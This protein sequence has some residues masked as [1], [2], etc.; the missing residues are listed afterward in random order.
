MTLPTKY[1]LHGFPFD[2]YTFSPS[3]KPELD[4]IIDWFAQPLVAS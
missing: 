3:Q 4:N 2:C 1:V